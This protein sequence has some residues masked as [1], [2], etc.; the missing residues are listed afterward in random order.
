MF[1]TELEDVSLRVSSYL[2]LM[3]SHCVPSFIKML[4]ELLDLFSKSNRANAVE[5]E[6]LRVGMALCTVTWTSTTRKEVQRFVCFLRK[7][8]HGDLAFITGL[9]LNCRV[10]LV[11]KFYEA[12]VITRCIIVVDAV[13]VKSGTLLL[14]D[15]S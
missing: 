4:S 1:V 9:K 7:H 14:V 5:A 2:M 6:G 8:V 15:V 10:K 12:F 3:L 11:A 13:I